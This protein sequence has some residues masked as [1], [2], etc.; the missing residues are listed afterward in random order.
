MRM[1]LRAFGGYST[2]LGAREMRVDFRG[3]RLMTGLTR[4]ASWSLRVEVVSGKL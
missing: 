1:T 3:G 4:S 2:G